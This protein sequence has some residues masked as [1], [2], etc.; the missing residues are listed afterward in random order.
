MKMS[1]PKT[2]FVI[3]LTKYR[4]ILYEVN[5]YVTHSLNSR[6]ARNLRQLGE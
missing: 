4:H 3:Y 5:T 1:G 2:M 6:E